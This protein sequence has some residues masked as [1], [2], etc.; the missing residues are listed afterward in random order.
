MFSAKK[1]LQSQYPQ[2]PGGR[3]SAT[4][5]FTSSQ[6]LFSPRLFIVI[7]NFLNIPARLK[8]GEVRMK[9]SKSILTM[10]ILMI[11]T[12]G[13][14]WAAE[15]Q[16]GDAS[17]YAD[18][19]DGNKTASGEPY[20]KNAF[21]AAHRTLPFGTKVKVTY[22]KT[23][24]TVD[25]VINDRGPHAKGR[26]IDLSGAAARQIGIVDDGHGKVTIEAYDK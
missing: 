1:R 17:Y 8:T 6:L 9:L 18:K 20:D 12:T 11:L 21:T 15:V 7:S 16:E 13:F 25:V 19:L 22:L 26:I 4:D 24:E 5:F 10:L 2:L 14:V 23:G 3:K